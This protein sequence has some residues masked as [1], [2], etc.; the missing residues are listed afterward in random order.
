[1]EG[2]AEFRKIVL[3]KQDKGAVFWMIFKKKN[4]SF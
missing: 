3:Y 2:L 1:M 4:D